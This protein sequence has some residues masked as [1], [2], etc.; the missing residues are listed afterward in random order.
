MQIENVLFVL[1]MVGFALMIFGIYD[2]IS[3]WQGLK[4]ILMTKEVDNGE[5]R[6]L[7][8]YVIEA[9]VITFVIVGILLATALLPREGVM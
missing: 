3:I 8:G 7:Q 4:R 1:L 2:L 5:I 6:L 9:L